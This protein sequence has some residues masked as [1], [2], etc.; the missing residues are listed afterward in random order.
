MAADGDFLLH[1]EESFLKFESQIFAEIGAALHSAAAA[2]ATAEHIA[3][4]E[5]L[6]EDV[7]EVLEHTGIESHALRS[8]AAEPGVAIAVVDGSFFGVG[9]DGVSFAD[10]FEPL[11][12]VRIIGIAV[13]MVLERKLAV[14]ALEFDVSDRA[15]DAQNLVVIAFYVGG[16]KW[17]I[18]VSDLVIELS[19]E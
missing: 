6:T 2:S 1:A 19:P 13:G 8:C 17:L 14:R 18:L 16:Q 7:A 12:R 10:F 5:E 15:S 11:L 3:E 9:K 4:A